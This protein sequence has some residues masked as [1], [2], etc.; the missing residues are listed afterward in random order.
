MTAGSGRPY[1]RSALR[2]PA[3][4]AVVLLVTSVLAMGQ[5]A[6]ASAQGWDPEVEG[7]E[8]V[9]V[10]P[11]PV[12]LRHEIA[13]GAA[14]LPLDAWYTAYG[15]TGGYTY[16]SSRLLAWDVVSAFLADRADTGLRAEL[17]D[18]FQVQPV[19]FEE[20]RAGLF[21]HLVF[22]PL[23]GKRTLLNG[24]VATTET[25]V[26]A[27]AG[28]VKY[29]QSVRAAVDAGVGFRIHLSDWFSTRLSLRWLAPVRVTGGLDNVLLIDLAGA[30]NFAGDGQVGAKEG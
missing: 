14:L 24:P 29:S 30:L 15:V 20:I 6:P 16:H 28:V 10:E 4:V 7:G 9:V 22:K 17:L 11:R 27:G 1:L 23:Y 8:V 12:E 2:A 21:S 5:A 3:V 13:F 26:V 19:R 18:R 25:Q